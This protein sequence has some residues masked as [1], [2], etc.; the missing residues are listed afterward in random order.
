M[1]GYRRTGEKPIG[2][3][4]DDEL[5]EAAVRAER[6]AASVAEDVLKGQWRVLARAYRSALQA[7]TRG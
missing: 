7:R 4:N 5:R 2:A 6:H 3:M 1:P